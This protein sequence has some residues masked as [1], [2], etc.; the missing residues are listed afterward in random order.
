MLGKTRRKASYSVACATSS[1]VPGKPAKGSV[2][3]G[4]VRRAK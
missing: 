4:S 3:V 1:P 2:T